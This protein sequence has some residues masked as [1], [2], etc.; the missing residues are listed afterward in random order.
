MLNWSGFVA[1]NYSVFINF[2]YIFHTYS[3]A[4]LKR[5]TWSVKFLTAYSFADYR[6]YRYWIDTIMRSVTAWHNIQLGICCCFTGSRCL[7]FCHT[8][9]S[10]TLSVSF[11]RLWT[12]KEICSAARSAFFSGNLFYLH[13]LLFFFIFFYNKIHIAIERATDD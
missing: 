13:I 5:S 8:I 6:C 9:E 10:V 11:C 1:L 12:V 2:F 3:Q 4:F 7:Y